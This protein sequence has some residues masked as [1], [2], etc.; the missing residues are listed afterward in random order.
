[1]TGAALVLGFALGAV[2]GLWLGQH[3]GHIPTG[4][5]RLVRR[6]YRHVD[7]IIGATKNENQLRADMRFR[8]I[9][10][11]FHPFQPWRNWRLL[12]PRKVRQWIADYFWPIPRLGAG[13]N[14]LPS[15]RR[16]A[17]YVWHS[18][19]LRTWTVRYSSECPAN[20]APFIE[21][22]TRGRPREGGG[23]AQA[24]GLEWRPDLFLVERNWKAALVHLT[25]R[26]RNEAALPDGPPMDVRS[27][28]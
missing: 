21:W 10:P 26:E 27:S 15:D 16:I 18:P 17:Q 28:A 6:V 2:A 4:D 14:P 9:H 23:L 20:H 5:E 8:L 7:E 25:I 19:D 3:R 11:R 22:L 13:T 1:M 24:L 12:I